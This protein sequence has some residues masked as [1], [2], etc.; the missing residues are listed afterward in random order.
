M[1]NEDSCSDHTGPSKQTAAATPDKQ[2][3]KH[4]LIFALPPHLTYSS[5]TGSL[6]CIIAC[7]FELLLVHIMTITI[8]RAHG[9]CVLY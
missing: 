2:I 1:I 3:G 6:L 9:R 5:C 4:D 8:K 7:N